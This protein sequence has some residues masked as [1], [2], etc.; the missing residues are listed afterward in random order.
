MYDR[1]DIILRHPYSQLIHLMLLDRYTCSD[2]GMIISYLVF[3]FPGQ[4]GVDPIVRIAFAVAT[5][6]TSH[7]QPLFDYYILL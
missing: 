3:Y 7:D 6:T 5:C 2:D 4:L 1:N